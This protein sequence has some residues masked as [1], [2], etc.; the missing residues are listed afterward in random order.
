MKLTFLGNSG[1][2]QG[3]FGGNTSLAIS[4]ETSVILVDVSGGCV[5]N[6]CEAGLD[7]MAISLVLL[8]H[9]HIDHIYAVPSLIHNLWL[10]GRT[11]ALR[12]VGNETTV[13]KAAELVRL[14]GLEEKKMMFPIEFSL[15]TGEVIRE[16]GITI[17][18]FPVEH[19]V[20]T[21]GFCFSD[22]KKKVAYFADCNKDTEIPGFTRNCDVLVHEAGPGDKSD[23]SS[24]AEAG[25]C[26]R[27]MNAGKLFLVHLPQTGTLRLQILAEAREQFA[28]TEIP[29]ILKGMEI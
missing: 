12:I 3:A 15:L 5:Q 13:R 11:E 17:Q 4:T 1:S 6:L 2:I 18:D 28:E 19:G 22:G 24:G 29:T 9:S 8:T 27:A 26:A 20:P 23:H 21:N 7:P 16:D 25:I 14:F 10:M